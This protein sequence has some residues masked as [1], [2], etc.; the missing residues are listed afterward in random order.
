MWN[1][2]NR[3]KFPRAY[4]KCN[5]VIKKR[6]TSKVISTQTENLGAGGICVI[7]K[8]DI[9][10]FQGV[11]VEL[12]LED[13]GPPIKCGGT[14]VWVVKKSEPKHKG[15][16]VYDTGVEFIDLRPEDR[17]RIIEVVESILKSEKD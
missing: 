14:V 2:I 13:K 5:I 8:E 15:S 3:R 10:L 16:Y 7:I 4:Y 17:E 11:D 9:G 12:Y 6:L 1:G